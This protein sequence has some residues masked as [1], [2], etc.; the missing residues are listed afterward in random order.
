MNNRFIKD[1]DKA[2]KLSIVSIII[3]GVAIVLSILSI[4]I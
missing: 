4:F 1:I 2:K 3:A